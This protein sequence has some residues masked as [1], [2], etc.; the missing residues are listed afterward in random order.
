MRYVI[1]VTAVLGLTLG[2]LTSAQATTGTAGVACQG[3]YGGPAGYASTFG[4]TN[5][6]SSDTTYMCP[7]VIGT[8]S[9]SS[10]SV[11]SEWFNFLD[12]STVDPLYCTPYVT[13]TSGGEWYGTTK[14]S[15]ATGGGCST[16]TTSWTGYGWLGWGGTDLPQGGTFTLYSNNN[17]GFVCNIPKYDASYSYVFAFGAN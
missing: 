5:I 15:C 8:T 4:M 6:G 17:G 3:A 12:E 2:S 10:E 16:S 11:S 1:G 13:Y 14:Y 9:G 7:I